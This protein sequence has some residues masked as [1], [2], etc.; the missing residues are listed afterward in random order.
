MPVG[1]SHDEWLLEVE[2]LLLP[3]MSCWLHDGFIT[4]W[5]VLDNGGV[6]LG[7]GPC[8]LVIKD[9]L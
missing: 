2:L 3:I 9:A 1:W 5:E 7:T 4:K 6:L 8:R